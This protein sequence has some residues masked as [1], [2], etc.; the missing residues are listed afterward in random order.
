MK[1]NT[2]NPD[3][4]YRGK[5]F[6]N[7]LSEKYVIKGFYMKCGKENEEAE[8]DWCSCYKCLPTRLP[9]IVFE[10][11][12]FGLRFTLIKFDDWGYV[13]DIGNVN[14]Q[15]LLYAKEEDYKPEKLL[16]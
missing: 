14:T 9:R 8:G 13:I 1:I 4:N 5:T 16:N 15:A 10:F 6:G 12:I 2:Y 3:F 7:A 11:K